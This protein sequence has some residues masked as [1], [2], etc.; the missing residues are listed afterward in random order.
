MIDTD[1]DVCNVCDLDVCE[2]DDLKINNSVFKR[3]GFILFEFK[4][5]LVVNYQ[6]LDLPNGIRLFYDEDRGFSIA[7][8]F[9]SPIFI[10]LDNE[11]ELK[12]FIDMLS[13][14]KFKIFVFKLKR[15]FENIKS[16]LFGTSDLPF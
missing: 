3:N 13:M 10:S 16:K 5:D 11:R 14:T 12:E 15:W 4:D 6:Y 7:S 2:F 8:I 9:H 1:L